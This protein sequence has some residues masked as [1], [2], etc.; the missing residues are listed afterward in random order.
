[1]V[2][3]QN[4]QS[5]PQ[6][7]RFGRSSY[8]PLSCAL[9]DRLASSQALFIKLT[10]FPTLPPLIE[11]TAWEYFKKL[12]LMAKKLFWLIVTP[13]PME[14]WLHSPD[15][16]CQLYSQ[17]NTLQEL[18]LKCI[19]EEINVYSSLITWVDRTWRLLFLS[20]LSTTLCRA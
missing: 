1:M 19:F 20:P 6:R 12:C 4:L 10:F 13:F 3:Q 5:P 8:S 11:V 15:L 16:S 7:S 18:T 2:Q 9:I 17:D 14:F